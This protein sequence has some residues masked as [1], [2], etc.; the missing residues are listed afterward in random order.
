MSDNNFKERKLGFEL[1]PDGCWG[2]NLR[3]VLSREQWDYIK[4]TAAERAEGRCMICGAKTQKPDTH[5]KWSYDEKNHIVKLVGII[6][7][8]RNCHNAIHMARTQLKGNYIAAE[9]HYMK[10]NGVSYSEMRADLGRANE[11][12]IRLGRVSDWVMDLSF[13]KDYLGL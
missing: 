12:N 1:V 5:E 4:K 2:Y 13:L 11:E 9:N 6:A 10:V 3:S 7:V 8:C